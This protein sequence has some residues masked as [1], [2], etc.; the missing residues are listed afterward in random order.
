MPRAEVAGIA[1]EV[2]LSSVVDCDLAI[3]DQL[4]S[5]DVL[6]WDGSHVCFN[7]SD[8]CRLFLEVLP[9]I[10]PGVLVHVHDVSLP[11]AGFDRYNDVPDDLRTHSQSEQFMLATFLLNA[12]A[13]TILL[14]VFYLWKTR[15]VSDHGTSFWFLQG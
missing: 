14:P 13:V 15:L 8:V 2:V 11:F 9:R 6:F 5:G 4:S 1:D 12:P 3:F 7:G 10:P